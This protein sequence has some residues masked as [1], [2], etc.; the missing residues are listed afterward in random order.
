MKKKLLPTVILTALCLAVTACTRPPFDDTK[1][2]NQDETDEITTEYFSGGDLW[3][4]EDIDELADLA[5][6]IVRAEIVSSRVE[7]QN[8]LLRELKTEQDWELFYIIY[9]VHELRVIETYKGDTQAG[10][11]I[12][13]RQRGGRLDNSELIYENH[14]P[15]SPG[16]DLVFFL[17]CFE[18]RGYGHPLALVGGFQGIFKMP[19][20]SRNMMNQLNEGI[21]KAFTADSTISDIELEALSPRNRLILTFDDLLRI[22]EESRANEQQ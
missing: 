11:I 22:S 5:T 19:S 7:R 12:E 14:L 18:I 20:L 13:T 15:L 6:D 17:H 2:E 3:V 16:D 1:N 4:P 21:E 10:D 9:T 8:M